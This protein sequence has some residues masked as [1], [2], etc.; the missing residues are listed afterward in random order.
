MAVKVR[1]RVLLECLECRVLLE[2]LEVLPAF[3]QRMRQLA[4]EGVA[5]T[6][7]W[8]RLVAP[9]DDD[10]RFALARV[11]QVYARLRVASRW[12]RP[13]FGH[14]Q[15][16]SYLFLALSALFLVGELLCCLLLS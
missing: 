1:G 12:A 2:C 13:V 5:N 8:E 9:I 10:F 14:S 7:G 11:R 6:I 16:L 4:A 3:A 15:E